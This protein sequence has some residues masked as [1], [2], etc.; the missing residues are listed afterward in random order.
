MNTFGNILRLTTFG[1]SHGPAMGGVIDGFPSRVIIDLAKV[2]AELDRRRPGA[3]PLTSQRREPDALQLLSGVMDYDEAT[4]ELAALH[5]GS[6]KVMT[7]G[8]SIGFII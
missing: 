5:A 3:S 2:Q 1:E 6:R 4:G 7:L 8:T